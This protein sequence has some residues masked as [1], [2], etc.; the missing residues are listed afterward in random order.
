MLKGHVLILLSTKSEYSGVLQTNAKQSKVFQAT[1]R[2]VAGFYCDFL[3][4]VLLRFFADAW[5]KR[6]RL[7]TR[8]GVNA[9]ICAGNGGH[10]QMQVWY[11]VST[12]G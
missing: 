9:N 6:T 5:C 8:A 7:R 4:T 11:R 1:T 2:L 10:A 12:S 3:Q